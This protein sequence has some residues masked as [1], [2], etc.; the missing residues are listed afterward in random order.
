MLYIVPCV[1]CGKQAR[2][3]PGTEVYPQQPLTHS[4]HYWVCECGAVCRAHDE[5]KRPIGRPANERTMLARHIAHKAL[6]SL[7]QG[8]L[9]IMTRTETYRWLARQLGLPS[10]KCHI[11]GMDYDTAMKVH[12]I[13]DERRRGVRE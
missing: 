10:M 7:W 13:A 3:V 2:L 1:E 6:D 8:R 9:A 4:H 12:R 11:S 5:T